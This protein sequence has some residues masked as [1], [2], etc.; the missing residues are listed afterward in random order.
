MRF[1]TQVRLASGGAEG[2]A[3]GVTDG[4]TLG[5]TD[6]LAEAQATTIVVEHASAGATTKTLGVVGEGSGVATGVGVAVGTVTVGF[7][8][9]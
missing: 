2:E 7:L 1:E 9:T 8:I 4:E 3:E 6:G 5:E